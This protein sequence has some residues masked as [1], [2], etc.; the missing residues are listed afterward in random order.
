MLAYQLIFIIIILFITLIVS[1]KNEFWI[2]FISLLLLITPTTPIFGIEISQGNLN[3][4]KYIIYFIFPLFI[5]INI[6]NNKSKIIVIYF[7]KSYGRYFLYFI[8]VYII[9]W[10]IY[11]LFYNIPFLSAPR[12][13]FNQMVAYLNCL[14][15]FIIFFMVHY[16]S[17]LYESIIKIFYIFVIYSSFLGLLVIINNDTFLS[18]LNLFYN[19]AYKSKT[20]IGYAIDFTFIYKR[21]YSVFGGG[22]NQY[23]F[24]APLSLIIFYHAYKKNKINPSLFISVILANI[25]ILLSSESRTALVFYIIIV[26][27]LVLISKVKGLRIFAILLPL[28]IL[29]YL[30]T[31]S[32]LPTRV[33]EI[34]DKNSFIDVFMAQRGNF[35]LNFISLLPGLDEAFFFGMVREHTQ[36]I[37]LF[38]ESGYINILAEG[39]IFILLLYIVMILYPIKYV[40]DKYNIDKTL[41]LNIYLYSIFI[42]EIIQGSFMSFRYESLNAILIS[43][44]IVVTYVEKN[45]TN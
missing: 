21:A 25:L 24:L 31:Y 13:Q 36:N 38:F 14:L 4:N 32:L 19:F 6:I 34:Y 41:Y 15:F 44:S 5:L 29:V 22:A 9:N 39:G 42:S 3:I 20:G 11:S 8:I 37:E 10:T 33:L 35:W 17:K 43:Y 28:V 1:N 26:L 16:H 2:I 7:F 18:F 40:S 27:H 23:G 30:I 12:F 45:K